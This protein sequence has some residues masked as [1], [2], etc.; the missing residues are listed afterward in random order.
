[1]KLFAL[2]L[3]TKIYFFWQ[4]L[5][6]FLLTCY[7]ETQLTSSVDTKTVEEWSHHLNV[8]Q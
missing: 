7:S 3:A 2:Y 4:N 1:M 6:G 5:R 8:I